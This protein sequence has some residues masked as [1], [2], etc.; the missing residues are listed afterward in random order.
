M[1][2][3]FERDQHSVRLET[4]YDNETAE[5]RRDCH[6]PGRPSGDR[7]IWGRRIVSPLARGVGDARS[8]P[9]AGPGADPRLSFPT[10]GRTDGHSNE[11]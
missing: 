5:Y 7:E 1:L 4:R 6:V 2:W 10:A 11:A 8:R 9:N 3:F